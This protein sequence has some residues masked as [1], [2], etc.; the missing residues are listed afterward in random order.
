M[1]KFLLLSAAAITVSMQ[2][3]ELPTPQKFE[4]TFAYSLSP[5]G[6][7]LA[8]QAY[9]EIKIVNLATGQ[10]DSYLSDGYSSV[11]SF[12]IGNCI[13]NTGVAVGATTETTAEYWKDGEWY[14]LSTPGSEGFTNLANAITVDGSRICGSLGIS[15]ISLD[16][17]ALMQVPVIWNAEGE[18]YGNPILLPHPEKDFTGRVPQYITAVDISE[19]GKTVVGQ[20]VNATGMI[21]YPIIYTEN[22]NGEWSYVIPN[23]DS[24]IP[25]GL[26]FPDYPG[27]GPD[28]PQYEDYMT[29]EELAAY[30]KAVDE[31]AESGYV[32]PYPDY[33]DYMSAEALAKF[34][35]DEAEYE[36]EFEAWAEKFDAWFEVFYACEEIAP[37]YI[38]NSIRVSPD[39]K[40]YACTIGEK[41]PTDPWAWGYSFFHVWVWNTTDHSVVKYDQNPD[42]NLTYLANDGIALAST[43]LNA[44][45]SDSFVL[46]NGQIQGMH[47]WMSAKCPE[48]GQWMTDNMTFT[49]IDYV[50][51]PESWDSYEVEVEALLSGRAVSTPDLSV[52]ALTVMNVWDFTTISDAYVFDLS[53]ANAVGSVDE[54]GTEAKIYDL[55]GRQLKNAPEKGIYIV[56]GKKKVVF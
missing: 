13:S 52:M 33:T 32:L 53:V 2:A 24:L 22:E 11:Y 9:D 44:T 45:A 30:N 46:S 55:A 48:Y 20:I 25:E 15:G 17:D 27:E 1:K 18:G 49:Y 12:G 31:C 38:F 54:A 50:F 5:N 37:G 10:T 28:A 23:E 7:Y 4:E 40:T 16:G 35:A 3:A 8:S 29:K 6:K 21:A 43:S 42:L 51:D 39:G 41:D 47:A 56:D 19:D 26:V 14:L 34:E 36:K